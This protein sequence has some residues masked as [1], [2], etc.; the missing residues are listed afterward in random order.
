[1]SFW[2]RLHLLQFVAVLLSVQLAHI[3]PATAKRPNILFIY[4]DDQ[5]HRTVSCFV[6]RAAFAGGFG[7]VRGVRL[8]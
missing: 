4:T 1:M 6:M 3:E 2:R 8:G 5:S 7:R